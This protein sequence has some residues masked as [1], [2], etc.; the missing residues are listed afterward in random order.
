MGREAGPR[1]T[2]RYYEQ[3]LSLQDEEIGKRM[4]TECSQLLFRGSC[5]GTRSHERQSPLPSL[6][7]VLQFPCRPVEGP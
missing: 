1:G 6:E 5:E 4:S 7:A 2:I 3:V